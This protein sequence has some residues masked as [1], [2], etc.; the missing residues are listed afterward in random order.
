MTKNFEAPRAPQPEHHE[1]DDKEYILSQI[2]H[3]LSDEAG[4][5]YGLLFTPSGVSS[6]SFEQH[7][8][9]FNALPAKDRGEDKYDHSRTGDDNRDRSTTFDIPSGKSLTIHLLKNGEIKLETTLMS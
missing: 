9:E 1:L 3:N 7:I 8:D 4:K 6:E 2:A 5:I